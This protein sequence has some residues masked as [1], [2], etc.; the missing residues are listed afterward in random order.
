MSKKQQ[1]KYKILHNNKEGLG[2][3]LPDKTIVLI[4]KEFK[5]LRIAFPKKKF[6]K[7]FEIKQKHWE[8]YEVLF[9]D[10]EIEMLLKALDYKRKCK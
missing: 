7:I 3:E 1:I 9:R 2:V 6:K 8:Y 10:Y 5:G 4:D